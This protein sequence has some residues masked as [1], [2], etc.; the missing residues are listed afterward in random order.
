M[1]KNIIIGKILVGIFSCFFQNAFAESDDTD[2]ST[3]EK[4][5]SV[6][7]IDINKMNK[8]YGNYQQT[9]DKYFLNE[10]GIE[11]KVKGWF[12]DTY[13]WIN[14][15]HLVMDLATVNNQT[16][17]DSIFTE[18]EKIMSSQETEL[19]NLEKRAYD[20]EN[21]I[22]KAIE[23]IKK[24][25]SLLDTKSFTLYPDV[26][27]ALVENRQ[28]FLNRLKSFQ[29]I[30]ISKIPK[31]E[32]IKQNTYN[33]AMLKLKQQLLVS[34]RFPLD[35]AISRYQDLV[36]TNANFSPLL[37]EIIEIESTI[38][39]AVLGFAQ[40]KASEFYQNGQRKCKEAKVALSSDNSSSEFKDLVSKNI[41]KVCNAMDSHISSLNSLGMS[42]EDI[43]FEYVE[44]MAAK[45]SHECKKD[46]PKINCEKF[47]ILKSIKRS[48]Y[49]LMRDTD[50]N[51][52]EK[53]WS[54]LEVLF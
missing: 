32:S 27:K 23:Y 48:D 31:L 22:T 25:D 6:K 30:L 16:I 46:S 50:L 17:Y 47:A 53:E 19:I 9:V 43:L 11:I 33:A 14:N 36:F 18:S 29:N 28:N 52:I 24:E 49:S 54:N 42:K 13:R 41:Y 51:F 44:T 12:E 21:L 37:Q 39:Q 2:L 1:S 7:I 10:N 3:R 45:Y 40:F 4:N 35:Q 20:I 15:W 38:D 8:A 34:G 5:A 26:R